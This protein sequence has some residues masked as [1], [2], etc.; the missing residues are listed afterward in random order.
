MHTTEK[1]LELVPEMTLDKEFLAKL[2]EVN[3]AE[4]N[5][6]VEELYEKT[7]ES[8]LPDYAKIKRIRG[9]EPA[10]NAGKGSDEEV[11]KE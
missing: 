6:K 11:E 8:L 1:G 2:R 10:N 5:V 7:L 9:V 3:W 4:F